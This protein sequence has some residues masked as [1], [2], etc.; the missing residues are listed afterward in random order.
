MTGKAK[1]CPD[2][3]TSLSDNVC[4]PAF[5]LKALTVQQWNVYHPAHHRKTI[6]PSTLIAAYSWLI[7]IDVFA[8][9]A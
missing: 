4:W 3:W 7:V 5:I 6:K 9:L 2:K 8:S 1:V